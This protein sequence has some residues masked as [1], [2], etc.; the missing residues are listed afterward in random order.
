MQTNQSYPSIEIEPVVNA[1]VSSES[2]A[3]R[4]I[5][6]R[7]PF[8]NN[9][10]H[11]Y[12]G[13]YGNTINQIINIIEALRSNNFDGRMS[14]VSENIFTAIAE[15]INADVQGRYGYETEWHEEGSRGQ[16]YFNGRPALEVYNN[17]ITQTN[18]QIPEFEIARNL[19][20]ANNL[21]ALEALKSTKKSGFF[22]EI[23]PSPKLDE[24]AKKRGYDGRDSVFVYDLNAGDKVQVEQY[25][26]QQTEHNDYADLLAS[27]KDNNGALI[28]PNTDAILSQELLQK[29]PDA[30]LMHN[31]IY[32]EKQSDLQ[33]VLDFIEQR[34][35][36]TSSAA[37]ELVASEG[38][39]L[40]SRIQTLIP[41]IVFAARSIIENP[42]LE[43]DVVLQMMAEFI[44]D[45]QSGLK[46]KLFNI[47]NFNTFSEQVRKYLVSENSEAARRLFIAE[48]CGFSI[49]QS[50]GAR[51]FNKG[52]LNISKVDIPKTSKVFDA[53]DEVACP[54]CGRVFYVKNG[55]VAT[56]FERCPHC[57]SD[58]VSCK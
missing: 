42:D 7:D 39:F 17:A 24:A 50:R 14:E 52:G 29:Y 49:S 46:E 2:L 36:S 56:Y 5:L 15:K 25:W 3:T 38:V 18:G 11:R 12:A 45:E 22:V 10:A 20:N 30:M 44:H 28:G 47:A 19:A 4:S 53:K 23:S 8:L 58:K 41:Q 26:F 54:S 31:F 21:V 33:P 40:R 43:L 32:V 13:Q 27:V 6:N 57:N 55:D 9:L 37:K 34:Q 16:M 48:G 1:H 51:I 35:N